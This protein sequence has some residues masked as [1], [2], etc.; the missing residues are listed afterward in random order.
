MRIDLKSV[1]PVVMPGL[2]VLLWYLRTRRRFSVGRLIAFAGFALYLLMVSDYTIFPLRFDSKYIEVFRNQGRF[3]DRVNLVP[4]GGWSLEYLT[5]IQGWG[6]LVL[7]M[8]WGFAY[9]FVVP[10]SGW[11]STVRSGAI[12]AAVIELTQLVISLLYGFAYRVVDIN[13]ILL[14]T[15]GVVVGY[16]VLRII[17]SSYQR[18]SGRSPRRI[19]SPD[20]GLWEYI[21]SV[22]LA[23]TVVRRP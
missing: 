4:F 10:V 7:G 9:P 8:P 2:V 1:L 21:E 5:S 18:I 13:D 20:A 14:N 11:R 16:A 17:A 15:A 3:F 22:L 6:N 19:D 23:V 12:F